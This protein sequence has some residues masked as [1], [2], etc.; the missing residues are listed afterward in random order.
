MVLLSPCRA[1][2]Y[3]DVHVS[4][5]RNIAKCAKEMGVE[6]LIHFS[7]LNATP[8]PPRYITRQHAELLMNLVEY[9][10]F[11]KNNEGADYGNGGSHFLKSKVSYIR[12]TRE[13]FHVFK[14]IDVVCVWCIIVLLDIFQLY[15]KTLIFR[16]TLFSQ[17][18]DLGYI[19]ETLF[20][21]FFIF[22]T[23]LLT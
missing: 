12:H 14:D 5:A 10:R 15:C 20:L 18:K 4:A 9:Q 1:Y 13:A 7:D 8:A 6:R 21:R 22:C 17:A 2:D 16:V 19:N 3:Y 23:I 11:L